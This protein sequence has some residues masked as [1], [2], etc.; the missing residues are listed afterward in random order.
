MTNYEIILTKEALSSN[1][2]KQSAGAWERSKVSF[3]ATG[4]S[5]VGCGAG[6]GPAGR[7]YD[8]TSEVKPAKTIN[9]VYWALIEL[10]LVIRY[11]FN[12]D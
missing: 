3:R 4:V 8:R 2:E 10:Q 7:L 12:P 6:D 11:E 5:Y 9:S 1:A